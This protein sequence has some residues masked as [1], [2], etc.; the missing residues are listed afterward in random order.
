[1]SKR[2]TDTTLHRKKWFRA[3]PLHIQSAYR[4]I[5]AEC[6]IA[7]VWDIDL[8]V[9]SVYSKGTVT[10]SEL[11]KFINSEKERLRLVDSDKLWVTGF[12]QFQY[13]NL[14]ETC[15]PHRPVIKRLNQLG[16]TLPGTLSG[17]LPVRLP[18]TLQ[19]EEEEKDKEKYKYKYQEKEEEEEKD[20][21]KNKE[22]EIKKNI[23]EQNL[24]DYNE[25]LKFIRG[26]IKTIPKGSDY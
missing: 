8:E 1:M 19:E 20:Q 2:F 11:L 3:A 14:V 5:L 7:G 17:T 13:G 16:L 26:A 24:S 18:L 25:R 4:I 9:L 21:E 12:V 22:K 23:A 10:L 6:D 15:H